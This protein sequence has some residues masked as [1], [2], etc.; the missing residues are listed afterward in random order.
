MMNPILPQ[1][2]DNTY[3]GHK[4]AL[5]LLGLVVSVKILQSL[6][7]IFNGHSIAQ[8]ADGIPLDTYSPAA[9]QTIVSLFVITGLSRLIMSLIGVLA[10]V[11]YRCTVPF[12]FVLLG[13][14]YLA[15]QLTIHFIPF[16]RTGTPVGPV[17]NFALFLLG[18]VG[19]ALSL[20][21][22][23]NVEVPD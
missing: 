15:R 18:I 19:L 7:V 5:W 9:A 6:S 16:V 11:R 22:Q 14:D 3:R 8:Y 2:I 21:R 13:L 1:Q 4:L 23:R 10:L 17:V 12:M 20:W